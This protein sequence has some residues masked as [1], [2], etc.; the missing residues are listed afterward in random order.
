MPLHVHLGYESH[1][2]FLLYWD[3]YN[4]VR[5]L[6]ASCNR[7]TRK[8]T[9]YWRLRLNFRPYLSIKIRSTQKLAVHVMHDNK[10]VFNYFM[11]FFSPVC[12]YF[13]V[14]LPPNNLAFFLEA[15]SEQ[16]I[17]SIKINNIT[18][19]LAVSKS[20]LC[21]NATVSL[22]KCSLNVGIEH[23]NYPDVTC[24]TISVTKNGIA[25]FLETYH[26]FK[27]LKTARSSCKTCPLQKRRHLPRIY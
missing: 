10:L 18:T 1:L 2:Y 8:C 17:S 12:V 14:P 20:K 19:T 27:Y 4:I 24:S 26:G 21:S 22:R 13:R 11:V 9:V 15:G 3:L 23:E 6:H 16:E 25:E 7:L 5:L